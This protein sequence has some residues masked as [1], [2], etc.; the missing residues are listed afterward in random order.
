MLSALLSIPSMWIYNFFRQKKTLQIVSLIVVVGIVYLALVKAISLIPENIDIIETWHKTF[1]DI[2]DFLTAYTV[3][4]DYFVR[5]SNLV[6][7]DAYFHLVSFNFL[8]NS[9]FHLV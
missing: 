4:F 6:L 9:N 2:Q 8:N 3:K 1:Y 7:G 5:I